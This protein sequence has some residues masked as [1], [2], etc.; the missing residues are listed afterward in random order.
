MYINQAKIILDNVGLAYNNTATSLININVESLV[1]SHAI[2]SE[3]VRN[4]VSQLPHERLVY[5]ISLME[6][7]KNQFVEWKNQI[8]PQSLRNIIQLNKHIFLA[9][10]ICDR[11]FVSQISIIPYF[12][13]IHDVSTDQHMT[14]IVHAYCQY[15]TGNGTLMKLDLEDEIRPAALMFQLAGSAIN[16]LG[17]A[18]YYNQTV[19]ENWPKW[20][21]E[22][23]NGTIEMRIVQSTVDQLK[24][25]YRSSPG[26]VEVDD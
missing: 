24:S 3:N 9:S 7:F 17:N 22:P 26:Y 8:L 13:S 15:V 11:N 2:N 19:F 16:V 10:N 18:D 5:D 20:D 21:I 25:W 1:S 14:D 4:I 12:R 6:E 23:V